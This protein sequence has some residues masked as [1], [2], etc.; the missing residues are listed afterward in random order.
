[1]QERE[2][3]PSCGIGFAK[4]LS[5]MAGEINYGDVMYGDN[6]DEIAF[7]TI[8]KIIILVYIITV[9]VLLQNLLICMAISDVQKLKVQVKVNCLAG[10][11]EDIYLMENITSHPLTLK[12]FQYF[13]MEEWYRGLVIVSK[14][15]TE[16]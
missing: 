15:D 12:L 6:S 7:K 14:D 9:L 11:L 8:L 5:M 10:R 4:L 16:M 13:G 1:M 3:L 2:F